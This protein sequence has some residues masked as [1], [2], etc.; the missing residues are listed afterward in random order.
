MASAA[1]ASLRE[2]TGLRRVRRQGAVSPTRLKHRKKFEPAVTR[3][4]RK[5]S[6]IA[7]VLAN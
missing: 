3:D 4:F 6:T 1:Q 2:M 5:P 7:A